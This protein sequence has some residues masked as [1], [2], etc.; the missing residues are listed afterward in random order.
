MASSASGQDEPNRTLWLA[1]R[2]G[3]MEPSCPLGTTRCIPQAKFRQKPYNKS[4]IDQVCSVKM[5]RYWPRSF[6]AS[7]WT[8]TSSR[9]INT[10]KKNLANIQPSWPHTWSITHTY[11]LPHSGYQSH[12]PFND[13]FPFQKLS[14]G[15]RQS[16]VS[17]AIV[18]F[19]SCHFHGDVRSSLDQVYSL[20]YYDKV[21]C[22][23]AEMEGYYVQKTWSVFESHSTNTFCEWNV[24]KKAAFRFYETKT[25]AVSDPLRR[26]SKKRKTWSSWNSCMASEMS[27]FMWRLTFYQLVMNADYFR[28]RNSCHSPC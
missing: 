5:A 24:V 9:S 28:R 21:I 14:F 1:T 16:N 19:I 10:Q 2:A 23:F 25:R 12:A 7:L 3:K 11:F 17:M 26:K 20:S 15:G 8:S 22:N 18:V 27:R 4:F 13:F 6:F